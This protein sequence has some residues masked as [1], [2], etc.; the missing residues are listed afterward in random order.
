MYDASCA[1]NM[2]Y[3]ALH[4]HVCTVYV[5]VYI[6]QNQYVNLWT[7]TYM[8][9][10]CTYTF[11]APF[12]HTMYIRVHTFAKLYVHVSN[13]YMLFHFCTYHVCQLLSIGT[14]HSM[15]IHT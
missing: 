14:V 2:S 5:D 3:K 15:Y 6:I 11:I 9:E 7:C 1:P 8:F 13:M 12:V 10:Q 4:V